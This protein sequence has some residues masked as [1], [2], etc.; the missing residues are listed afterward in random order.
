MDRYD[1]WRNYDYYELKNA[2][3][4]VA[5]AKYGNKTYFASYY[6]G[7]VELEGDEVIERYSWWNTN[8]GLDTISYWQND[9]RMAISDLKFDGN[10]NM[11]GL[12]SSVDNPLFVKTPENEWYKFPISS[13]QTFLF[14]DI[15]I[16]DHNQKWGIIG[17]GNGMFVYNDNNT[18]AN[19]DDDQYLLLDMSIE[20]GNLPSMNVYCFANDLDGEI[21]V[22]TDKGIAVFYD[23]GAVFSGYNFN[24]Q[25]ILITEGSYGQYLLSEEKVTCIAIDG[26]NRKWVGTEKSGVFLLSEDGQEEVLHFTKNNS[27]LFSDNIIDI[28]INHENG[29]VFIGNE[30]GL[31]SY[32]SNA[33]KG[34]GL[35]E[36]ARVFPNP[37]NESYHG[38]IAISGLTNNA[39][40]KITDVA[41][42]L[43][44][45]TTANGGTAIWNGKN[46][47]KERAA[48]GI[49]LVFSTDLNGTE[50]VV[51]KIVFVN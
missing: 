40:V 2:R 22:G 42:N 3:D 19:L 21:W 28:T 25:Q 12:L 34:V 9:N 11:W 32:R 47:N 8:N 45:E 16:D 15:L 5:V 18:I 6:N 7:V 48:T 24:A 13:T 37:V 31:I 46:K 38:S 39:N 44:F 26:A 33:T 41:G 23:P 30:K 50:K 14:D 17:R 29:E 10:G 49:Y 36:E 27:P 51:S 20:K 43:V 4:I 35:Q 1:D